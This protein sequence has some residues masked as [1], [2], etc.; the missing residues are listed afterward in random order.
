MLELEGQIKIMLKT[1]YKFKSTI[2]IYNLY[3]IMYKYII[4]K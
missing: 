4:I 2:I 1:V 3:T